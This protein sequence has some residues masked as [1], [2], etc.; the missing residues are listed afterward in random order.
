MSSITS[1]VLAG[2]VL[3]AAFIIATVLWRDANKRR[4]A[5]KKQ[6]ER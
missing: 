5:A 1:F 2:V 6:E 4:D 3:A